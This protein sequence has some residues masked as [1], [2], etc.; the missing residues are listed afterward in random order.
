M[1]RYSNKNNHKKIK[2]YNTF[3]KNNKDAEI[4]IR[5]SKKQKEELQKKAKECGMTLSSYMLA[6]HTKN[7][8]ELLQLIPQTVELWDALNGLYQ[9]V[10]TA[11]SAHSKKF[12]LQN[13]ALNT[14]IQKNNQYSGGIYDD[15]NN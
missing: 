5:V 12:E 11:A 10:E 6:P 7:M 4:K 2:S 13:N 1:K 3:H 9:S 8:I 14:Y 15:K